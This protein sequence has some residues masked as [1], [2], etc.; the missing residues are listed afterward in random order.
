MLAFRSE[1][2][3]EEAVK[4]LEE[5]GV[6]FPGWISDHPWGRIAAFEDPDGNALQL[7]APP[8]S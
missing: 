7:Y 4:E 8:E 2:G 1:G 5:K 3:I 6:E